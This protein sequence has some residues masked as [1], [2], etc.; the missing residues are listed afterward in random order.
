MIMVSK[1]NKIILDSIAQAQGISVDEAKLVL[2]KNK[3]K[4]K[5]RKKRK[6]STESSVELIS[7]GK[8]RTVDFSQVKGSLRRSE[9]RENVFDWNIKDVAFYIRSKY[10]KRYNSDWGH[11]T[12]G[13]CPELRRIHDRI[14]DIYG[15]CDFLVM[16]DY[17]DFI[18]EEY[19]DRI[20][21]EAEGVFY[22]RNLR[23]DIYIVS[24]SEVYD[25]KESFERA[26]RGETKKEYAT[27]NFSISSQSIEEVFCLSEDSFVMT[28]GIVV[29]IFWL[30][31][32]KEYTNNEAATRV[33]NICKRLYK[34]GDFKFVKE[35]TELL[36]PY[37]ESINFPK[38]E[39][40]LKNI[41]GRYKIDIEY[42]ENDIIKSKFK[43][44]EE[45]E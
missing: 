30:I 2:D 43:F 26:T 23:N 11:K 40:F 44:L 33:L 37:H 7:D 42:K 25:Y 13:V 27:E 21:D 10:E 22:L 34:K 5:T 15:H 12:I 29:C 18:F 36:S 4:K 17:I 35:R 3:S 28:Y 19:I 24:F 1:P 38:M 9:A 20:V 31:R 16:R 39:Q 8:A 14:L 32:C 41:D 45:Q 6:K